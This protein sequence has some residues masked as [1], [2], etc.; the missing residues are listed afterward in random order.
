MAYSFSNETYK[1]I[2][3]QI[4][5]KFHM[6]HID[7][8]S[9]CFITND[10]GTPANYAA[11]IRK[12]RPPY[13]LFIDYNF[14]IEVFDKKRGRVARKGITSSGLIIIRSV[15]EDK[16]ITAYMPEEQEVIAICRKAGKK[17]VPPKLMEK[18]RKNLVRHPEFLFMVA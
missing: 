14:Y 18:V 4:I 10:S 16:I 11:R 9:I 12:F 7:L 1:P 13:D 8:D 6:H 3:K 2:A 5:E 17:C 15:K